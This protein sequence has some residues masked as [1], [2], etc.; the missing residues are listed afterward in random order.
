MVVDKTELKE[1]GRTVYQNQNTITDL[2][3]ISQ[4][5]LILTS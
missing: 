1:D 2:L 4:G 3:E 5:I